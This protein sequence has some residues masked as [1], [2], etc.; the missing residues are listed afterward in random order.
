MFISTYQIEVMK[1]LMY[2]LFHYVYFFKY[3]T[4]LF[5]MSENKIQADINITFISRDKNSISALR[6]HLGTHN[7]YTFEYSNEELKDYDQLKK[8]D[9]YISPANSYGELKGGIDMQYYMLLGR[10]KLQKHI[11]DVI[12]KQYAGEILVGSSCLIKLEK[13]SEEFK[14][15]YLLLC[16]TMTVP[17]DVSGTRNAYYFTRA[18]ITG[19][20]SMKRLGLTC[21]NVFCPTPCVGVGNMKTRIMAMQVETAFSAFEGK[22]LIYAI[23]LDSLNNELCNKYPEYHVNSV[24]QNAKMAYIQMINGR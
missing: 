2:N 14:D 3:L 22:G 4:V 10:D 18:M 5:D 6:G 17:L 24:D 20:K 23:Y 19:L 11:F 16:P 8:Y 15:K 13:I 1:I 9:V 12:K 21:S 7:G